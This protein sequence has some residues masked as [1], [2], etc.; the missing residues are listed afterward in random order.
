MLKV[1]VPENHREAVNKELSEGDWM[2]SE[3][4]VYA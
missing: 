1:T 2:A 4:T 3:L